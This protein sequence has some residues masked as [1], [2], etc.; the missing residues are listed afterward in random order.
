MSETN[1][2]T[3]NKQLDNVHISNTQLPSVSPSNAYVEPYIVWENGIPIK[4]HKLVVAKE[5]IQEM[6]MH[7]A[8]QI[9][10]GDWDPVNEAFIPD[11]RYEGL[12]KIEVAQHKLMDRA[13]SGD[14][15]AL[16][17][18]EDRILGKPKQ[19]VESLQVNATLESFLENVAKKEGFISPLSDA[20]VIDGEV[21]GYSP[22]SGEPD[23]GDFDI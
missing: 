23:N 21:V 9:Y 18:I 10:R 12:T 16:G 13:A 15:Q 3:S 5:D 22:S 6:K 4:K 11:P 17:Q 14:I 8:S 1:D 20:D 19:Q 7:A 2:N